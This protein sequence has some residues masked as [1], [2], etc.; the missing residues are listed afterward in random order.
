MI[1]QPQNQKGRIATAKLIDELSLGVSFIPNRDLVGKEIQR[2]LFEIQ[3]HHNLHDMQ[4][5]IWTKAGYTLG[6]IFPDLSELEISDV[7]ADELYK[8]GFDRIWDATTSEIVNSTLS[9]KFDSAYIDQM[10]E[11]IN[12]RNAEHSH[13]IISFKK[14]YDIE[15]RGAIECYGPVAAQIIKQISNPLDGWPL[16]DSPED[17]KFRETGAKNLMYEDIKKHKKIDRLRSI[18]IY[19]SIH[20]IMRWDKMRQFKKNDYF[21]FEHAQIALGYCDAFFT[22]GP[23]KILVTR[24]PLCLNEINGCVVIA[25]SDMA[26]AIEY[27]KSLS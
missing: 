11:E 1:K 26:A 4:D 10:I 9:M 14:S 17:K 25:I 23:L 24:P 5:L 16:S 19:S 27:L 15:L 13:E 21:D 6:Y 7:D 20:A 12:R 22:E 8:R 18:H 3:G 2:W